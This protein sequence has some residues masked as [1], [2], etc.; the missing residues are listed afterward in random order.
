MRRIDLN[1]DVGEGAG[2]DA[3]LIPLITSANVACGAHAGDP[4]TMRQTVVLAVQHGVAI[5]AHPGYFDRDHFGRRPMH[6]EPGQLTDLVLNQIGALDAIA[7]AAGGQ[8]V[9]VKP[10]GALYNQ[11]E[12]DDELATTLMEAVR[13]YPRPLRLV[14]RAGSAMERAARRA[15]FPFVAEAFAD[16]RYRSDGSLAPRSQA[17]SV[18]EDPDVVAAQVGRLVKAGEVEAD[19]GTVVLV[20]FETLCLHGDTPGAARL[21]RRVRELFDELEITAAAR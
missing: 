5:G 6:L 1:A 13:M 10:H 16:R 21:A 18:L 15:G 8:V 4:E 19:D 11:A 2:D 9:H 17:G 12:V 7:A 14:G 20:A 3:R